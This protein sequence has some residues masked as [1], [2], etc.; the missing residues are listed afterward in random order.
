M[1][2]SNDRLSA[3]NF[4]DVYLEPSDEQDAINE[5]RGVRYRDA[6]H[7]NLPSG[8]AWVF[9]YGVVVFWAVDEDERRALLNRLN[10]VERNNE[11]S[12]QEHFRFITNAKEVRINRDTISLVDDDLLTRLAV[13]H[14]LAQSLKLAEYETQAQ[15]TIQDH[16]DLP[17]AL[18]ET[19]KIAISRREIAKIRG[20]LFS[21]KSDIILHYGLLDTPEFFWEYPE[22]EAIYNSAARYLEIRQRV[23]LLSKKLETIHEMFEMLADE[24]KHQH[25]SFLEW[26]IIILIAIE[27]IMFGAQEI[28]ALM[29]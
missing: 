1:P 28:Q 29:Q 18:A 4:G 20:R 15:R 3:F 8:E 11:S 9:D 26:I 24:M 2:F 27:I 22:Y 7:I 21:T 13:S 17:R 5:E 19:G 25:S 6:V 16:S 23:D 12:D 14:A 10:I